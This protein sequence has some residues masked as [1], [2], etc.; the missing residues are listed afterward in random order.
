MDGKGLFRV[1][2]SIR[3]ELLNRIIFITGDL[4]NPDTKKFF[5]ENKCKFLAKPFTPT[6][7]KILISDYFAG[8]YGESGIA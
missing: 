8:D 7:L 4:V 6:D 5:D 3:P 1:V 2:E